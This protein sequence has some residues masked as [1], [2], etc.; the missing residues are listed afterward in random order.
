MARAAID[1]CGS[2]TGNNV[3]DVTNYVML[4]CGQPLHA[5]DLDH[6]RGNKIIVRPAQ[7]GEK[8]LAIDHHTYDLD[9]NTVVIAD[10]ERAV[11]LGG[12][13]GGAESEVSDGTVNLLIESAAFQPLSIRRTARRLKLHS[14]SSF[15]FERRPDPAGLDWASRRCC[16]LIMEVAGGTLA[17]GCVDTVNDTVSHDSGR[18]AGANQSSSAGSNYRA[19]LASMYRPLK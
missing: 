18:Q 16:E 2:Q 5:F 12:V 4:E 19:Y 6:I 17:S 14:P 3:V 9:E 1:S 10:A 11:A 13:M 7:A 15:R 8:F